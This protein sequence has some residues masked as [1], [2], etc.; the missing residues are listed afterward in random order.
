VYR[1][2]LRNVQR[3]N[4]RECDA[5]FFVAFG[6]EVVSDNKGNTKPTAL[7]FTSGPQVFIK[8]VRDWL[9]DPK[10]LGVITE[11]HIRSALTDIWTKESKHNSLGWDMSKSARIYALRANDPGRDA[12]LIELG[13]EWLAFRAL[14]FFPTAPKGKRLETT[15]CRGYAG[16]SQTPREMTWPMWSPA[17]SRDELRSL[18]HRDI[19]HLTESERGALGVEAV[20]TSQVV[21]SGKG[22]GSFAPSRELAPHV[23]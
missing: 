18:F 23:G 5:D 17:I 2:I 1:R 16:S 12:S 8:P 20:F 9:S 19:S 11:V 7:H 4:Q 13:A 6:S 3:R 10:K 21:E 14:N 15:L 22:Y